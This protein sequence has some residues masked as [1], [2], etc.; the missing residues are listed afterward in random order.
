MCVKAI[1]ISIRC[2]WNYFRKYVI[3]RDEIPLSLFL[4]LIDISYF[5]KKMS[6]VF[7]TYSSRYFH[8]LPRLQL[9]QGQDTII[10]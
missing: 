7:I 6:I 3:S 8:G 10:T 2:D 9:F 4:E 5:L 1:Y